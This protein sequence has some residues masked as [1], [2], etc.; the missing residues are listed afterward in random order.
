MIETILPSDDSQPR[1]GIQ[2]D[3]HF[4]H[5]NVGLLAPAENGN[6]LKAY[7]ADDELGELGEAVITA[8][9]KAGWEIRRPADSGNAEPGTYT[10]AT[11][12]NAVLEA[13]HDQLGDSLWTYLERPSVNRLIRLLRKARDTAFGADA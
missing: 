11:I 12:G 10:S 8:L 7:Y 4:N 9:S 3:Q 1:I 6:V 2:Y 5:V 13:F